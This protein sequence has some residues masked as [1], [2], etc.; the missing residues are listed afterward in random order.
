MK[1]ILTYSNGLSEQTKE[2][3]HFSSLEDSIK[4]IEIVEFKDIKVKFE[5]DEVCRAVKEDGFTLRTIIS[6]S[7]EA[8]MELVESSKNELFLKLP[9]AEVLDSVDVGFL[10]RYLK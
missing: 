6:G 8:C 4:A 3:I 5:S 10:K 7:I 9:N 2:S 1:F